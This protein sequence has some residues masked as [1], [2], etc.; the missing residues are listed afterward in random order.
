MADN[1]TIKQVWQAYRPSKATLFWACVACIALV[2]I[3]GFGWGGWV[4]GGTAT[5]M[6]DNAAEEAQAELAAFFCVDRFMHAQDVKEQLKSLKDTTSW[7]RGGFIKD[8]GWAKVPGVDGRVPG[9]ADECA[10]RLAQMDPPADAG[11]SS[12]AS[13]TTR[14]Q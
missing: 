9:A 7:Q 4:T 6:A 2:P 12:E 13:S 1:R 10:Q 14:T 5:K 3:I 11:A 8:G